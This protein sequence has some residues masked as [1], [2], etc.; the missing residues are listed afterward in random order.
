[1]QDLYISFYVYIN[2]LL[3]TFYKIFI[4]SVHPLWTGASMAITMFM[5]ESY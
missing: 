5:E 3:S 2:I 1:M 4:L